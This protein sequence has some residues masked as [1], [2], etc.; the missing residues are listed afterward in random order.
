[1]DEETQR[2]V[3]AFNSSPTK[4]KPKTKTIN[5]LPSQNFLDFIESL[6]ARSLYHRL[7]D[8]LLI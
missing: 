6:A 2:L 3:I 8:G 7:L 4:I 1:M 5:Q